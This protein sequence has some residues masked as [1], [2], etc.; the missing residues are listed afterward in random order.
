MILIL[1]GSQGAELIN[2]TIIDALPRLVKNYQIIHQTGVNNYQMVAGRS[3]I[4]LTDNPDRSRYISMPFLNPLVMKMAAGAASI[5]VSRAGSQLFEIA[6]WGIPSIL[7]PLTNTNQDHQKKNAFAYA[8]A[9]GCSV[10]EEANTTANILG[11]EIDRILGDK[12]GYKEMSEKAKAFGKPGAA[13]KIARV[14][15]E[16]ALSHD[17]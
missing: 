12:E 14:I 17:K 13:E 16:T 1:G 3:E 7:I 4:V 9:G 6:S 2:N 11:A 15:M 5:I 8:R 10:I